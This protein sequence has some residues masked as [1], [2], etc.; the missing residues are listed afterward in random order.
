MPGMLLYARDA[1]FL[2]QQVTTEPLP[3]L[4]ADVQEVLRVRREMI[5]GDGD[6]FLWF[7]RAAECVER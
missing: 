1:G 5:A 4:L 6:Q 2:G 3:R 7:S